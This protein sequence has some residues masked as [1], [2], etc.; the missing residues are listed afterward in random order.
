MI[1]NWEAGHYYLLICFNIRDTLTNFYIRTKYAKKQKS[2]TLYIRGI[3]QNFLI[4]IFFFSCKKWTEKEEVSKSEIIQ[5]FQY[6][7]VILTKK[8]DNLFKEY[9]FCFWC[10]TKT[11]QI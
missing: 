5:S 10:Y 6:L 7:N 3:F 11:K 2:L 1:K 4:L 8:T 9:T